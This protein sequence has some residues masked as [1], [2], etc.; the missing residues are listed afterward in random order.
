VSAVSR[1]RPGVNIADTRI[2]NVI[3][4]RSK[5][6]GGRFPNVWSVLITVKRF[7]NPCFIIDGKIISETVK[8]RYACPDNQA[9]KF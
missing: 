6:A 7:K 1:Y 2:L 3:Y 8:D 4:G 9:D 5:S